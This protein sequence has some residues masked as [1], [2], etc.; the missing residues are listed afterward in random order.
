MLFGKKQKK[1]V[2][3]SDQVSTWMRYCSG[4]PGADSR[5]LDY[6][7]ALRQVDSEESVP[8]IA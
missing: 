4:D 8:M 3:S 2:E 5:C 7:K 1:Q 6:N